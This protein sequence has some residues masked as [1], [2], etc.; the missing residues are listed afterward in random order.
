MNRVFPSLGPGR[1]VLLAVTAF[2]VAGTGLLPGA[3]VY[4]DSVPGPTLEVVSAP[5]GDLF[6]QHGGGGCGSFGQNMNTVTF[7]TSATNPG[8]TITRS[9]PCSISFAAAP[10]VS[11]SGSVELAALNGYQIEDISGGFLCGVT[12]GSSL[13]ISFNS[14]V[15][16][17][18]Q[19]QN[20]GDVGPAT[21]PSDITFA[22]VSTLTDTVTLSGTALGPGSFTFTSISENF[23][24]LAPTSVPEPNTL[25]LLFSGLVGLAGLMRKRLL[26]P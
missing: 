11:Q 19:E 23:S 4:A 6:S 15:L 14:L 24:L 1:G 21:G 3:A 16:T 9:I 20:V 2:L 22:P 13:S 10:P 26:H 25:S 8:V 5:T 12:G 7:D 18:P 17:C